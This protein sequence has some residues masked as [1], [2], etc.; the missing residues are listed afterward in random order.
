MTL[1]L[2]AA[3]AAQI[4]LALLHLAFPGRFRWKEEAARMSRLNEQIFHVHT[5]FVC[6]V[7]VLFGLVSLLLP[8]ELLR[9]DILARSVCGGISVFWGLRFLAQLFVYDPI[10]WKGRAF[11]TVVHFC[12]VFFWA[13]L[14]T[15]YGLG[16]FL[17]G[18]GG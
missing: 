10:L 18:F 15:I 13:G 14:T 2:Q 12:F 9:G 3:G 17:P 1:L 16:A 6:V 5:F 11:E 8:A 7:L 4:G